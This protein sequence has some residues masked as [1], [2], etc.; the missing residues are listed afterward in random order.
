MPG[1]VSDQVEGAAQQTVGSKLVSGAHHGDS[2]QP[3]FLDIEPV[4]RSKLSP[5]VEALAACSAI[6]GGVEKRCDSVQ[7]SR[8][9]HNWDEGFLVL[10]REGKN[11]IGPGDYL[12]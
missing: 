11:R 12:E 5:V 9:L 10:R 7:T 4:V 3:G 2:K 1:W 6:W 8:V